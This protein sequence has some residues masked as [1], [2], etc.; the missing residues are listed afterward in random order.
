M[1]WMSEER[2]RVDFNA[3]ASLVERADEVAELLG[4]SRT[5]L[6]VDALETELDARTD[7]DRFRR[8]VRE[9]FY[10]GRISPETVETV[11]GREEATRLRLLRSA[12]DRRP[13][14]PDEHPE[15]PADD[16]Y[17]EGSIPAFEPA[18]ET[19]DGSGDED[20]GV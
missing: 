4:V 18:A 12:V 9:A 5:R 16:A 17:Y 11:L 19:H 2:R 13:P 10:E 3:P 6:L 7:G 1:I 8:R 20:P 14:V 15:R